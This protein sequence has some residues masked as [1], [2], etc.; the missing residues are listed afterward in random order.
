MHM[1]LFLVYSGICPLD[2]HLV[3]CCKYDFGD[4]IL[5]ELYTI[6]C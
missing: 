1:C 5:R 6:L 2:L 4:Y 3:C